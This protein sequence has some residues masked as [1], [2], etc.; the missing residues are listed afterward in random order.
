[1]ISSTTTAHTSKFHGLSIHTRLISSFLCCA[2]ASM[3][4]NSPCLHPQTSLKLCLD[5]ERLPSPWRKPVGSSSGWSR[6]R[7]CSPPGWN[8]VGDLCVCGAG[9]AQQ[10]QP[11]LLGHP[12]P[13]HHHPACCCP[14]EA[15][16]KSCCCWKE[17]V[18]HNELHK[19]T[20]HPHYGAFPST[21]TGLRLGHHL[22]SHLHTT[23]TAS[24]LS[25][26]LTP[27]N[28]VGNGL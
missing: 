26:Q 1:M 8:P 13:R 6:E 7:P 9:R 21:R 4:Q 3:A 19:S 20:S 17:A 11:R 24:Y 2:G 16:T 10:L 25:P 23:A 12:S 15:G 27:E 14:G 28:E 18:P 22:H 5:G